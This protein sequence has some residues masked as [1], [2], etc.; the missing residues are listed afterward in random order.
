MIDHG[1]VI[2]EGTPGAAQG[3]AW[4][5]G[6][7]HVRLLD[8]RRSGPPPSACSSACSTRRSTSSA[9]PAAL[10]RRRCADADEARRPSP[11]SPRAGIAVADFALGQPSLDEVFL[12]LTGHAA[13]PTPATREEDAA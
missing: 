13:E 8:P 10:T 9:D 1:R 3:V 12:A 6:A 5:Q 2:A 7:L 11:R 4:A